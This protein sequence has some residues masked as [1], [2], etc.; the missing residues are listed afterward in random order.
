MDPHT[1]PFAAAQQIAA[2]LYTLHHERGPRTYILVFN[3]PADIEPIHESVSYRTAD[4]P[5]TGVYGTKGDETVA[6]AADRCARY[7]A[8]LFLVNTMREADAAGRH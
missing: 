2:S 4:G 5:R 3:D 6:D 7:G 1:R 8:A